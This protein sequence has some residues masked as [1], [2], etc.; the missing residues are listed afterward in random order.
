MY[1]KY[2]IIVIL[3]LI[4]A[5]AAFIAY[6][7]QG[8]R[9]IYKA[10]AARRLARTE[11][12]DPGILTENDIKYLPRPVQKY[13]IYTGVLGKEKVLNYRMVCEGAMKPDPQKDWAQIRTEQYSFTDNTGRLYFIQGNFSG[14]P[15]VGM[16]SYLDRK[17]SMLIK[18]GGLIKVVDAAGPEMDQGALVT[19]FNDMCLLAPATLIDGRIRWEELDGGTVKASF[20]DKGINISAV[21][22]FNAEGQ[23]TNFVTD[24]RYYSTTGKDYQKVRWSTPVK[25]YKDFNG[26]KLASSGEAIWHFPQGDYCYAKVNIKEVQ[27]NCKDFK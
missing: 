16:D 20:E 4:I 22:Y 12:S 11:K 3:L 23:M 1:K 7:A 13:L 17:G 10:E 9:R 6:Q 8:V 19:L 21:L 5:V 14:L 27:Y 18:L 25:D 24:D 2:I 26:I 15:A